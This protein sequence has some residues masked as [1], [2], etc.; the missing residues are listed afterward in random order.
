MK[1]WNLAFGA[2]LIEHCMAI[3]NFSEKTIIGKNFDIKQTADVDRLFNALK[4]GENI[5]NKISSQTSQVRS[6]SLLI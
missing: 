6:I 2:P 1:N 5:I 4:E 3:G